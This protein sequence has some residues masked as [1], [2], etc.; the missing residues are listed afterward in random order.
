VSLGFD[1]QQKFF[2]IEKKCNSLLDNWEHFRHFHPSGFNNWS[3][4]KS[5]ELSIQ[6]EKSF[7]LTSIIYE[8][9][10][11]TIGVFKAKSIQKQKMSASFRGLVYAREII[12][13]Q[14]PR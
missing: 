14:A 9:T 8:L 12:F 13:V 4:H 7:S 11:S 6:Q 2:F 3:F 10:R 1:L 5:S